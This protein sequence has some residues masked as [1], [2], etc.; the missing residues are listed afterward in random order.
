MLAVVL[1]C[2]LGACACAPDLPVSQPTWFEDSDGGCS[3]WKPVHP[4]ASQQPAAW[5]GGS[6]AD[7]QTFV[8]W[9]SGT[10]FAAIISGPQGGQH[11]WVSVRVKHVSPVK[12]R[13]GVQMIDSETCDLVKPGRVEITHTMIPKPDGI[14]EY[15]GIP[16]FV[17]EPCKI[18]S[19]KLRVHLD[20]SDMY[21]LETEAEATITPQYDGFCS[22]ETDAGAT[23]AVGQPGP[24]DTEQLD[25]SPDSSSN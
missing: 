21:G 22:P 19:R 16:A 13:M 23:D 17:K 24:P 15:T 18:K 9:K 6:D 14:F 8:D 11:I 3:I 4:P 1:L 7:G 20:I 2:A 25:A 5:I 10:A 12:L